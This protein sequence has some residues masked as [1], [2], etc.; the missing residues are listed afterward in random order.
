[1]VLVVYL[2]GV[3]MLNLTASQ[4]GA[5]K[6]PRFFGTIVI[7]IIIDWYCFDQKYIYGLCSFLTYLYLSALSLTLNAS[8]DIKG[9]STNSFWKLI[10]VDTF[11]LPDPVIQL[12]IDNYFFD[13]L[14]RDFNP[15]L[16]LY[17]TFLGHNEWLTYPNTIIHHRKYRIPREV[18]SRSIVERDKIKYVINFDSFVASGYC[19]NLS[20]LLLNSDEHVKWK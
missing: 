8:E 12:L 14:R 20:I 15:K 1:M 6:T 18:N 11:S 5:P 17:T 10:L 2:D 9:R 4:L 16:F 7:R 19:K 3:H 13:R